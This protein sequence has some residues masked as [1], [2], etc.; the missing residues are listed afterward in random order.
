MNIFVSYRSTDRTLVNQ[1]VTDLADMGH[2][3]WYDQELQGGQV[4]WDNILDKLRW[5]DLVIFALTPQSLDSYPCQLEYT[6]GNALKRALIPVQLAGNINYNLLPVLLQERQIISYVNRDIDSYKRLAAAIRTLP[7]TPPLPDPLPEAPPVPISPLAPVK[8]K[9]DSPTL[10]YEQQVAL[11]HQLKSYLHHEDYSSDARHLLNRLSQHPTLFASVLRDIDAAL[12][13][14]APDPQSPAQPQTQARP[15][16]QS[17]PASAS[18]NVE[19]LFTD[20][21]P[22]IPPNTAAASSTPPEPAIEL[23]PGETIVRQLSVNFLDVWSTGSLI[24]LASGVFTYG[25][26][27]A[28]T[29]AIRKARERKLIVTD[30]RLIFKPSGLQQDVETVEIPLDEIIDMQKILKSLD[31]AIKLQ[32]KSGDKIEFSIIAG[33][34]VGFGNREELITLVNRLKAKN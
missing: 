23:K 13:A 31:P 22:S 9:I 10:T 32:T 28:A 3:V 27:T 5:C 33:G 8:T 15:D 21:E 1:L 18:A 16:A 20:F 25:L 26:T 30:Q 11:L 12:A 24:G 19:D 17:A 7:A 6:Y 2:E 14:P 29:A 34:G 4:W